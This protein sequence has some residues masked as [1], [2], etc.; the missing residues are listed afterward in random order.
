VNPGQD[1]VTGGGTGEGFRVDVPVV[2]VVADLLINAWSEVPSV[3]P[4]TPAAVAASAL[5][6]IQVMKGR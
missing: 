1:L 4:L 6:L 3:G 5:P 2:D